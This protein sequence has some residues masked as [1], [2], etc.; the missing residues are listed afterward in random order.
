MTELNTEQFIR[1]RA[2]MGW[3]RQMVREALGMGSSKFQV[4]AAAV[5]DV[6]WP[7]PGQSVDR[8]R[9]YESMKGVCS[10]AQARAL[11]RGR[12]AL[13]IKLSVYELCG[14]RG[15][16]SDLYEL[17]AEHISVTRSTVQRRLN[18]G[19]HKYDAFFG[20]APPLLYR[21]EPKIS[22]GIK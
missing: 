10:S 22:G 19:M 5:P 4:V 6:Q 15:T 3:S 14:V 13:R 12:E 11:Q 1:S 16:V 8:K 9:L 18:A 21:R 7:A 2:A 20:S 17:W